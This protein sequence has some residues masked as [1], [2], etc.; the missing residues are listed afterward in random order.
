[1]RR[2]SLCALSGLVVSALFSMPALA[3]SPNVADYPLRVHIV[4]NNNRTHYH[5]RMVDYVDG[6]GRAILFENSQPRGFDYGF[7][8]NDRVRL[9]EG[10]ETYPARWKKQGGILEILA[11]GDGQAGCCVGLRIEGGIEGHRLRPA[12]WLGRLGTCSQIQRVDGQA[13]VRPRAWKG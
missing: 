4:A 7:R 11:A 12:Q 3:G 13:P 5:D 1:M 9:S 8:C 2:V 10:F 6:E